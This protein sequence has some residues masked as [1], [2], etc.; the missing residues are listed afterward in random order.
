MTHPDLRFGMVVSTAG[1]VMNEV[2]KND[3]F[4]AR[5][6]LVV[7]DH[8]GPAYD[9]AHRR[10]VPAMVVAEDDVDRF[11]EKILPLF[12]ERATVRLLNSL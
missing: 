10:G 7:T 12:A 8:P 1:S 5:V 2:L 11:C 3:F 4:R 6:C 9:N